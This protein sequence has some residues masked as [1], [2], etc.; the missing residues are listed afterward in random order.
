MCTLPSLTAHQTSIV[1]LA[2]CG[3]LRDRVLAGLIARRHGR[4]AC[5]AYL[6]FSDDALRASVVRLGLWM[7][8]D[9]PLRLGHGP[10][11]W[12]I[13]DVRRLIERKRR[14]E[15]LLPRGCEA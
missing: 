11:A 9:R 1:R 7:P 4:E 12:R 6:G 8:V 3:T 10:N 5:V 2:T 15:T 14:K 13:D